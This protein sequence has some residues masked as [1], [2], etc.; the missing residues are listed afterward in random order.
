M[1]FIIIIFEIKCL[2]YLFI[3]IYKLKKKNIFNAIFS[4]LD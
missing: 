3:I 4:Q 1:F 2:F